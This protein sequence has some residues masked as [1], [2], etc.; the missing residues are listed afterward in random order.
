M[1]VKSIDW[2]WFTAW[3]NGYHTIQ[4]NIVP[5]TVGAQASLYGA[6]GEGTQFAGIR[7]Y[8]KRLSNGEDQDIDFGEWT[9]WPPV[10][11][12][13]ISSVTFGI[14]TGEDQEGWLLGRMDH[15][16]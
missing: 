10:V 16:G 12:D 7:H 14:A 9:S 5:D 2:H 15:W 11:F 13:H 4:V 6:S 8:R 3:G 1:T